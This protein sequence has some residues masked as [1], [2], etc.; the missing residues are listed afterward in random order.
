MKYYVEELKKKKRQWRKKCNT[1]TIQSSA[2]D[3]RELGSLW[4]NLQGKFLKTRFF[5]FKLCISGHS[6][7]CTRQVA[8]GGAWEERFQ[9]V[10][11][12]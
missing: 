7:N 12:F 8:L 5:F 11:H 2:V 1:T 10:L 6:F 9:R 3:K 4:L